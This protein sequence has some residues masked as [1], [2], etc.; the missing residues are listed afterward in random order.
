MPEQIQPLPHSASNARPGE[1]FSWNSK[2]PVL[3]HP[4]P[5]TRTKEGLI[6]AYLGLNLAW[7]GMD[8]GILAA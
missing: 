7:A 4:H 5:K 8:G 2:V 3:Y 1:H 6:K